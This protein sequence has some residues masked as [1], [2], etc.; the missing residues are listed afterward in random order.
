MH[1]GGIAPR[2]IEGGIWETDF[3]PGWHCRAEGEFVDW[4]R[5]VLQRNILDA[6][7]HATAKKRTVNQEQGSNGPLS[8]GRRP[9]VHLAADQTSPSMHLARGEE[10]QRLALA[11]D[12]LLPDQQLVVRIVHLEGAS[13]ADAAERLGRSP[14]AI[15]KLLQRGIKGLRSALAELDRF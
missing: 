11:L 10:S 2:L 6:V 13:L 3:G 1:Q 8:D 15:A 4:L 12:K 7:R 14:A 9:D 5:R